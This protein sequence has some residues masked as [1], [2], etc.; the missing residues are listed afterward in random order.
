MLCSEVH[1]AIFDGL[2][3]AA[4]T[5]SYTN[6][7]PEEA[8]FC[9]AGGENCEPTPHL[10]VVVTDHRWWSCLTNPEVGEELTEGQALWFSSTDD[11]TQV[12]HGM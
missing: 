1:R 7:H 2:E 3:Q 6:L 12:K 9:S 11:G 8:I 4:E 5:L 10:A